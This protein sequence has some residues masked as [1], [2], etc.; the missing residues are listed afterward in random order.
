MA[1]T[2]LTLVFIGA[3]AAVLSGTGL[4]ARFQ[5]DATNVVLSFAG[6]ITWGAFGISSFDVIVHSSAY[7]T[8]SEPILPLAYLGIAFSV[9]VGLF[10]VYQLLKLVQGEAEATTEETMM[11]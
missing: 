11:P 4:F 2:E 9:I 3:L 6:A 5:D 8:Q 10:A 7:A 1:M